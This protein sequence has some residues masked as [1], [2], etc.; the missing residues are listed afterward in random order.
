[1]Q[2]LATPGWF[3]TVTL[4]SVW[5]FVT[6]HAAEALVA[7][8]LLITAP[9]VGGAML[10][11]TIVPFGTGLASV[12]VTVAAATVVK[13]PLPLSPAQFASRASARLLA[14]PMPGVGV[15]AGV[16]GGGGAAPPA[17]GGG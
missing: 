6:S 8:G 14:V 1:M 9:L 2:V 16:A 3:S 7:E 12:S 13:V 15:V 17:A 11:L 10:K 4:Q 5:K